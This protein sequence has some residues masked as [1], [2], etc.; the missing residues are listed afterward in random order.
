[1]SGDGEISPLPE[2]P[3]PGAGPGASDRNLAITRFLGR[4]GDCLAYDVRDGLQRRRLRE[5]APLHATR[6]DGDGRAAPLDP[7]FDIAWQAV[8]ADLA[9]RARRYAALDNPAVGRVAQVIVPDGGGALLLG[10]PVG[11]TLE[12]ALAAGVALAPGDIHAMALRLAHVCAALHRDGLTHLD[13]SPAT[14]ALASGAPQ[15]V[16]FAADNRRLMPLTH[17]QDGLV[18]PDYSPL[19]R[20]DASGG[21]SL[22][23]ATD[24]FGLCAIFYR[25]VAGAP[26]APWQQR[27]RQAG[28][29]DVPNAAAFDPAF[30]AAIRR[31]L[32]VEP[33][34]RFA[35][36]GELHAALAGGAGSAGGAAFAG[37][38]ASAGGA[39]PAPSPPPAPSPVPQPTPQPARP[40]EPAPTHVPAPPA[41]RDSASRA[42]P[43]IAWL[44]LGFLL[45]AA[46]VTAAIFW[47][48]PAD[49]GNQ[50]APVGP[51][52]SYVATD[53][54]IVRGGPMP[55]S[56]QRGELARGDVVRGN[57]VQRDDQHW[58]QITEGPHAGGYVW[59]RNLQEGETLPAPAR[60]APPVV[61]AP[62]PAPPTAVDRTF[63]IGHWGTTDTCQRTV[64]FFADQSGLATGTGDQ[65]TFGWGLD[66]SQL[67][68]T[69]MNQ[70][71]ETAT[72]SRDGERLVIDGP[73]D[74]PMVFIRCNFPAAPSNAK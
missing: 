59:A 34:D 64:S 5:W 74:S 7:L 70:A 54:A 40:P 71:P 36:A 37:A 27:W 18:R 22:G 30:I 28:T 20:F 47:S 39:A 62:V 51:V 67:V 66:G 45:V 23:P 13:L 4:S 44:L 58:L 73:N 16:D 25:L 63:L 52:S 15:L 69:E 3:I 43:V 68:V 32:A 9:A 50:F 61:E 72:V 57:M 49:T 17:R 14:I 24:V 12:Q 26:P 35:D 38:T 60:V 56:A 8:A 10:D 53:R 6:R 2:G 11:E 1:M 55:G 41:P 48:R 33:K 46:I 65:F 29:L 42:G 31:G 21:E 19:E